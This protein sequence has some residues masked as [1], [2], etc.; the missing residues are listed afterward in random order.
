MKSCSKKILILAVTALMVPILSQAQ[1]PGDG[2]YNLNKV[3]DRLYEEMIPLCSRMI[4][5]GRA[6]AGFAALWYIALRV[7]KHI[8]R[9]E[10]VDMFPLLRPFAI[11]LAIVLF[12]GLVALMNGV[13]KPTVVATAAMAGDS[14]R[15]IIWHIEQEEKAI[16]E[17]PPGGGVDQSDNGELDKY[18]TPTEDDKPGFFSRLR[19]A[20]SFFSLKNLFKMFITELV[21]VLYTTAALCINTIRTFYL[22]V[23]VILG[24]LVLGLSVFDGF[25]HILASWFARYIHVYLWLPVANIFGAISSKILENMF[26]LDQGFASTIA[27]CIFMLISFVGYLTVPNVAG[28]I[29]QPGGRDTLLHKVSDS[30]RQAAKTAASA[31]L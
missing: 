28:Y 20:F 26:T 29:I 8:A 27:Y 30:T 4:D 13:L 14:K 23:L 12:P 31:L 9:A 10:A 2:I 1:S 7:W 11:G 21:K 15:A 3:L 6:I 24:P 25:S 16:K 17:T 18:E 5:V 19:S 22:I